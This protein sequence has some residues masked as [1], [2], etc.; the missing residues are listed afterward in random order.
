MSLTKEEI[1]KRKKDKNIEEIKLK[2]N[3]ITDV[4]RSFQY[5]AKPG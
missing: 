4:L 3:K 2:S 5:V 1:R